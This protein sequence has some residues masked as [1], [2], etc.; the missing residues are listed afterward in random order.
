MSPYT[1]KI[2]PEVLEKKKLSILFQRIVKIGNLIW[3]NKHMRV[4]ALIKRNVISEKRLYKNTG[5]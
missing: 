1:E 3:I 5:F 4:T 2:G